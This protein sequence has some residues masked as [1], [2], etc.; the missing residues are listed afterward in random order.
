MAAFAA[1]RQPIG[2]ACAHELEALFHSM[3]SGQNVPVP[4]ESRATVSFVFQ[5]ASAAIA[6]ARAALC[7]TSGFG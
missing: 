3:G 6:R 1:K 5:L 2:N 4:I 7:S